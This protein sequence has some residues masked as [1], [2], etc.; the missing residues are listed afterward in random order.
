MKK[1][2]YILVGLVIFFSI[3]LVSVVQAVALSFTTA[4]A[5][6]TL[7]GGYLTDYT[8]SFQVGSSTE[9]ESQIV[10]TFPAG[11]DVSR[12]TATSTVTAPSTTGT[13]IL[14]SSTVSGQGVIAW[15]ADGSITGASDTVQVTI[16]AIQNPY[17]GNTS[18]VIDVQTRT[19]AGGAIDAASA[20]AISIVAADPVGT[21]GGSIDKIKPTSLITDPASALTLTEGEEYV[22]KGIST[23]AGGSYVNKVEVSV[24]DGETW[25]AAD[26][27]GYY[28]SSFEW[29]YVW[30]NT[31]AGDYTIRARGTDAVGNTETPSAGVKAT[32][33]AA[34]ASPTPPPPETS[35][36]I[37]ALEAEILTLKETF[38]GLLKKFIELLTAQL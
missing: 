30:K 33:T 12:A 16:A 35:G 38:I 10:M 6:T 1:E 28:G 22:I 18:A 11:F 4:T 13:A 14:A 25:S 36:E 29:K 19:L 27:T 17:A 8:I 21:P 20:T 26:N 32:V 34:A 2:I 7:Y 24:D 9:V 37:A 23:D 15:L 5:V 3:A 31:T